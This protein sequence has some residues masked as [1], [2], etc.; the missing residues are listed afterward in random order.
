MQDKRVEI[1]VSREGLQNVQPNDFD[2][3]NETKEV[4]LKK[5]RLMPL[6]DQFILDAGCGPGTYGLILAQEG[7]EVVGIDISLESIK[8]AKERAKR[9]RVDSKFE[10]VVADLEN[11]PFRDNTFDICFSGWALHHFPSLQVLTGLTKV[12]KNEGKMALAEPN[13]LHLAIRASRHAENLFKGLFLE[14][15]LF[16]ENV[17]IHTYKD[18]CQSLKNNGLIIIIL[19]SC[20]AKEPIVLPRSIVIWKKIPLRFIFAVRE[21]FCAFITSIHSSLNGTDVLI[22]SCKQTKSKGMKIKP[23][24][25]TS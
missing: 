19:T 6:Q 14:T 7:N 24:S 15:G 9:K 8:V 16:T 1:H 13:E 10:P 22:L 21:I 4:R 5:L 18:Y 23:K 2:I 12:L 20:Y 25:M 17:S 11:L 3:Q